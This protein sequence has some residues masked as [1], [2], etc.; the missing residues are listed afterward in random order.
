[1]PGVG[2]NGGRCDNPVHNFPVISPSLW[3]ALLQ[4]PPPGCLTPFPIIHRTYSIRTRRV[5]RYYH[6]NRRCGCC[7][8][9]TTVRS[10]RGRISVFENGSVES[11]ASR[12]S[13]DSYWVGGGWLGVGRGAGSVT[14]LS[15]SSTLFDLYLFHI[16]SATIPRVSI[17]VL[18]FPLVPL[19][20]AVCTVVIHIHRRIVFRFRFCNSPSAPVA[21][22]AP[23]GARTIT[24]GTAPCRL[25][26]LLCLA[27]RPRWLPIFTAPWEPRAQSE[28][29]LALARSPATLA[30]VQSR[31]IYQSVGDDTPSSA[32]RG[33]TPRVQRCRYPLLV[34]IDAA[35]LPTMH[36]SCG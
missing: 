3:T 9:D 8:P 14:L 21:P 2:W 13:R 11:A 31:I 28:R 5:L 4:F 24:S 25:C 32:V 26:S 12:I 33:Y 1:M 17:F 10:P 7:R 15:S 16:L 29:E 20:T 27:L 30:G 36:P 6:Q 22:L 19:Y 35:G 23:F 18:S 34:V